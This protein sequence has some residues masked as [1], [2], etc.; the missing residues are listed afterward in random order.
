[1]NAAVMKMI[2]NSICDSTALGHEL[3]KAKEIINEF[4]Y[5]CSHSMRGFKKRINP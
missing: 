2:P 3:V 1:M 4:V 5:S